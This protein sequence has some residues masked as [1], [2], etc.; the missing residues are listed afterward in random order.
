[1]PVISA[2]LKGEIGRIEVQAHSEQKVRKT[3]SQTIA[4]RGGTFLSFQ[5][6][7]KYK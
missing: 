6:Y 4:G 2:T 7:G 3:P 5:L 1:M